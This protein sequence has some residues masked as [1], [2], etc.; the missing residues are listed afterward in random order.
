MTENNKESEIPEMKL[1][2]KYSEK[3]PIIPEE[4]IK[5]QKEI[6]KTKKEIEKLKNFVIKKYSYIQAIGILPPQA[7]KEFI[8]EEIGEDI[9]KE[10]FEKLQK[11]MH[12][13]V[14]IPE[15]NVKEIPALGFEFNV[16]FVKV[17]FEE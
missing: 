6:E 4:N 2:S 11:K 10:Q 5:A 12:L 8:E 1:N 3:K 15:E 13:Y 17:L 9:P 14:I 16:L 7:V